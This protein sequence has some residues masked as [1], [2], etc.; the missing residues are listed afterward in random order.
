MKP[1]IKL[2]I[3]FGSRAK[4][5]ATHKSDT[6]IAIV[7]DRLLSLEE[8]IELKAALAKTHGFSEDA[9]DLVETIGASPLL[10]HE[11]AQNGKLLEGKIDDFIIFKIRAWRNYLDTA[12]LRAM[13]EES[14]GKT[15]AR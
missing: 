11:I 14:L 10:R 1:P 3:L 4:D 5:H 9:I 8:K 2:A 15:Y 6:D 12:K 13:R 7:R